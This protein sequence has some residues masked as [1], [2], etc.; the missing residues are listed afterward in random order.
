MGNLDDVK[1]GVVG[2]D[3]VFFGAQND[4]FAPGMGFDEDRPIFD[5]LFEGVGDRSFEVGGMS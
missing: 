1:P 4:L 3:F 5:G 2:G